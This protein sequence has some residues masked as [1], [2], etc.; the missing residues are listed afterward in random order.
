MRELNKRLLIAVAGAVLALAGCDSSSDPAGPGPVADT[1]QQA[2]VSGGDTTTT[3]DPDAPVVDPDVPATADTGPDTGPMTDNDATSDTGIVPPQDTVVTADVAPDPCLGIECGTDPSGEKYC[4][5]CPSGKDCINNECIAQTST[6]GGWCGTTADC[7]ETIPDPLNPAV[8]VDNPAYPDCMHDQCS[9]GTC[10]QAGKPGVLILGTPICTRPCEIYKDTV[11]NKTGAPGA[12]G[13]EDSDS[14]LSDCTGFEDGPN[15]SDAVCANFGS[16]GGQVL[17]YCVT[18]SHVGPCSAD[19]DCPLG[20]ACMLTLLGGD[21]GTRCFTK[22]KSGEWGKAA[23]ISEACNEYDPFTEEGLSFCAGGLCFGLGCVPLCNDD[24]DCDTTTVYADTGC[25]TE[26]GMCKAW[27]G[28]ACTT[29]LDCSAWECSEEPRQIFSDLPDY[30]LQMC[31][32][33]GC[34]LDTDCADGF[35]CRYNW[36]GEPYPDAAWDNICLAEKASGVGAGEPCDPDPDDNIPGDTCKSEDM[37]IGGY[38]SA[39][40]GGD[41][42]CAIDKDQ[43]CVTQEFPGDFDDDGDIDFTLTLDWCQ[44]FLNPGADCLSEVTCGDGHTCSLYEVSNYMDDGTGVMIL[45]PDGPYILKGICTAAST[46]KGNWGNMCGVPG[47]EFLDCNSGICIGADAEGGY[48]GF[49]SQ[50]CETNDDC[51]DVALG[52]TSYSGLCRSYLWGWGGDINDDDVNVYVNFCV[53]SSSSLAACGTDFTCPAATE[54]CMPNIKLFGPDYTPKTDYVCLDMTNVDDT[55]PTKTLGQECDPNA[56]AIATGSTEVY[57]A[58]ECISGYCFEDVQAGKGYCGKSC[59]PTDVDAC[60]GGT[61]DMACLEV[62]LYPRRG[63]YVD[64]KGSFFACRKDIDCTPCMSS[65]FCPGDRVCANLGQ[66]DMALADY[67]CVPACETDAECAG[68][69][70]ATCTAGKDGNGKGVM[71]CFE[72]GAGFPVNYCTL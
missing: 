67:R 29:D 44:T 23:E 66:D 34:T 50:M 54:A 33:K 16:P 46:D 69:K 9:G 6:N 24:S 27:P 42:D 10:L 13:I 21:I 45:N 48:A 39:L 32:P 36:N 35:Y 52:G 38:C 49:C 4:G 64:N 65:G 72:M 71:G 59:D 55:V 40:C 18:G 2:D 5:D 25:D 62:T 7:T 47:A 11:N 70:A 31:W 15:G 43:M 53:P 61:P 57:D 12:D 3:T 26:T 37:C 14:P 41:D 17:G 68:Q 30:L 58:N 20:E 19:S 60:T 22:V 51:P 63:T 28:H 56:E 8:E 1:S